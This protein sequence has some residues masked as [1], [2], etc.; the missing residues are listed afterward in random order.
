VHARAG[1]RGVRRVRL[2]GQVLTI[3]LTG[4]IGAGKSVA[5]RRLA[6]LGAVV[7]DADRV[8]REVVAP[9]TDGLREVVAAFG[10]EVLDASGVLDRGGLGARVFGDEAARRRLEAIIHPRVRARTAALIAA[11]PPDAIVVNDVPLLV[12]SGLAATY[13]LVVVVAAAEAT[14]V[15]RLTRD[16]GMSEADAYAR[17]RAQ[18]GDAQRALAADVVLANDGTLADLLAAV[19]ALWHDR[20]VPYEANLRAGR[21]VLRPE[22]PVL[23]P[24]DPTWPAQFDRLAAR[25]RHA[26]GDRVSRVDHVGSTA[27]PGMLAED[28]I[29][30][31]L[32]VAQL[33]DADA[34]APVLAAAGFPGGEPR[35]DADGGPKRWHGGADPGR[36]VQLHVREE[37]SPGW[38]HALLCRDWLR[39]DAPAAAAYA[40][41]KRERAAAGATAT[42]YAAAIQPRVTAAPA[43]AEEWAAATGWRP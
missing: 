14:R 6:G 22:S 33:A 27:V 17:I 25:I 11:A 37:G 20:L 29:D 38:R 5:A 40:Q 35:R 30:I 3:G 19:D 15:A 24:Y 13:H 26:A 32:A 2:T 31:Q 4:G 42:E 10:A 1:H 7:I 39:A 21:V 41:A 36:I 16:R 34:L 18:A 12:E 28:V 9:G 23:V 8:A 43:R